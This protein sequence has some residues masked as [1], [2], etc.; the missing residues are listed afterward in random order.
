M[1]NFRQLHH[2]YNYFDHVK[3]IAL[4]LPHYAIDILKMHTDHPDAARN[5]IENKNG[6][7]W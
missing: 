3:E 6:T 5:A 7:M 2:N 1:K 4:A